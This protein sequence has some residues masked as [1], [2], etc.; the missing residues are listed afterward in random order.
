MSK[1][2]KLPIITAD[3]RLAETR[4]I[5]GC[6]L[7]KAGIGKTSLLW[8]LEPASTLFIDLEAGDLAVKGWGGDSIRPKTW[9][10]CRDLAVF[11]GGANAAVTSDK[12]YSKAH[13]DN[14]VH[15]FGD[16]S[17]LD[18][19]QTIFIDSITVAGRLCLQWCKS[20]PQSFSERTG[21]EDMRAAY[22]LH[23]QEMIGWLTHLQ[24]V[25]NKNIWFVAVLD[26]KTDDYNHKSFSIQIDGSKTAA[27]LPAIVDQLITMAEVRSK[28]G[29]S[30]RAFINHTIN[31]FGFPAKDRSGA[32][33][34]LEQPHLSK[35]MEK[36]Q[37]NSKSKTQVSKSQASTITTINTGVKNE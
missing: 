9:Q 13:Y 26:E 12:P 17:S 21:K 2:A 37:L 14:V 36:I 7:G 10:Q 28:D 19:Y 1:E 6:I 5:K 4:G 24:H 30:T 15:K 34:M 11:L 29:S 3:E 22:G 16:S 27:E 25:R 20:Q 23:G 33:D 32:L 35:L 18:K 31:P 8:T